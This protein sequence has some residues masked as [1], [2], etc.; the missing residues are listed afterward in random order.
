MLRVP[1]RPPRRRWNPRGSPCRHRRV[2]DRAAAATHSPAAGDSPRAAAPRHCPR[3]PQLP[4]QYGVPDP[5]RAAAG[6]PSRLAPRSGPSH[7]PP[8]RARVPVSLSPP[9][10]GCARSVCRGDRGGCCPEILE[11]LPAPTPMVMVPPQARCQC[12][13]RA[14]TGPRRRRRRQCVDLRRVLLLLLLLPQGPSQADPVSAPGPGT[15]PPPPRR[16]RQE[17]KHLLRQSL[18]QQQQLH[19]VTDCP[20]RQ[21]RWLSPPRRQSHRRSMRAPQ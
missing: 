6:P 4:L 1:L 5:A 16:K 13:A 3:W 19:S 9:M 10:T 7:A 12:L 18:R 17:E 15:S 20:H 8:A 14:V 11:L 2:G 21:G